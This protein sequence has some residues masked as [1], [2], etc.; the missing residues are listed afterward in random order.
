MQLYN[1]STRRLPPAE[2]GGMHSA[3]VFILP[4]LE[5][6]TLLEHY[7]V[8]KSYKHPDNWRVIHQ[9]IPVYLCPSM[10]LP[11][12]VPDPDPTLGEF[13][14][15]GS[16]AVNTGSEDSQFP[17]EPF[18]FAP[19]HNGAIVHP[20]AGWT[21][22]SVIAQLDGTSQ[23]FLVGEMNYGF[24]NYKWLGAG[25]RRDETRWGAE[26]LGVGILGHH[27]GVDLRSVQRAPRY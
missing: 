8:R 23:T 2:Q 26:P 1:D 17:I 24:D 15:P 13:G 5:Q 22:M 10:Y 7:T 12:D 19:R 16:Y 11:R 3:F 9:V 25:P 20:D 21:S 14:A 6:A 4:F 27:L 18:S